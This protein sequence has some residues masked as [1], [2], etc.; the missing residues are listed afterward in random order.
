MEMAPKPIPSPK[1][2]SASEAKVAYFEGD[3]ERCLAICADIRVRSIATASEVALLSARAYLRSGRPTEAEEVLLDSLASHTS[4]DAALTA[5]MLLGVARIRRGDPDD[6]L[7]LLHKAAGQAENAHFAVRAEIAFSTALGYW[8]KRELDL[9]EVY[10]EQVDPRSDIIHARAL[11]LRAWCYDAR[12]DYR[13]AA[14]FFVL[15]LN[16]LDECKVQDRAITATAL[17]ILAILGAELVDAQLV[18]LVECR[19][20]HMVWSTGITTH[21]YLCLAY[22]AHYHEF[23]GNSFQA[24]ELATQATEAAPTAAFQVF[25]LGLLSSLARNAGENLSARLYA[26]RARGLLK[27]LDARKFVGEE[28]FAML[29]VAESCVSFD[30]D[31]AKELYAQYWGLAPVDQMLALAGDQRLTGEETFVAGALAEARQDLDEAQECYQQAFKIFRSIRYVRRAVIAAYA[32]I[33]ISI[34]N[35]EAHRYID[36]HTE[37][38][39]NYITR[40]IQMYGDHRKPLIT[41]PLVTALPP[42]QR[43]IVELLCQGRS[44]KEIAQIRVVG[45]QTIKNMLTRHIFPVFGVSSRTALVSVCLAT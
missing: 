29:V 2:A 42:A 6:G 33:R 7:A 10:L 40:A 17:S 38:M 41:H 12:R 5:K 39:S 35:D 20:Q 19:T 22:L 18:E 24:F 13:R 16:R 4:L 36:A 45:E 43:E 14:D 11:E 44:N 31:T 21:R 1:R 15:T 26:Q 34:S 37:G 32:L 8:A 30:P 27:T 25:G 23:V 3:F 9:V 28:R